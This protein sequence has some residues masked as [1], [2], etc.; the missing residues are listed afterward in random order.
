MFEGIFLTFLIF[1]IAPSFVT[2]F[3]FF[4][5]FGFGGGGEMRK[6]SRRNGGLNGSKIGL[7]RKTIHLK[8]QTKK[9]EKKKKE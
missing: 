4:K 2:S 3:I 5:G 8:G 1:P 7:C 6:Y 9:K